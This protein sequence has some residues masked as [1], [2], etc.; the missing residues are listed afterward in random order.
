MLPR[1]LLQKRCECSIADAPKRNCQICVVH[2]GGVLRR[3]TDELSAA[4]PTNAENRVIILGD[5]Q[6]A[7]DTELCVNWAD[8]L[9]ESLLKL[10]SQLSDPGFSGASVPLSCLY[11]NVAL[12]RLKLLKASFDPG[13]LFGSGL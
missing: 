12:E 10:N 13:R 8:Q 6:A 9:R 5:G 4:A 11:T 7:E 2:L 1:Q 3:R